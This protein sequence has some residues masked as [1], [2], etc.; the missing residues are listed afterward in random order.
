MLSAAVIIIQAYSGRDG[1]GNK[2]WFLVFA[3]EH[4][5]AITSITGIIFIRRMFEINIFSEVLLWA[6]ISLLNQPLNCSF[7]LVL[8]KKAITC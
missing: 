1:F 8:S 6:L 3:A 7:V 4:Y 5:D 2:R